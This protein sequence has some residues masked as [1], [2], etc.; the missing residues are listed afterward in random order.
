MNPEMEMWFPRAAEAG[1][2]VLMISQVLVSIGLFS[3]MAACGDDDDFTHNGFS[4]AD[5]TL[6]G[7]AEILPGG[8]LRLTEIAK[9]QKGYAFH[10]TPLRLKKPSGAASF[11]TTFVIAMVGEYPGV[12][13]HGLTFVLS[14]SKGI[15]GAL[16]SQYLGL[17]N[18]TSRGDPSNHLVA[19]EFDTNMSAEF[20][21]I[22]NNHVGIDVNGVR[23]VATRSLSDFNLTISPEN[24]TV[25]TAWVDYSGPLRRIDVYMAFQGKPK[26]LFPVLNASLDLGEHLAQYSYFGFAAS[27][28]TEQYELNCILGW[29]LTV[30]ILPEKEST[31]GLTWFL[32]IGVPALAVLVVSAGVVLFY[33]YRKS[34]KR[35]EELLGT[36]KSLPG[37]PR[38]FSYRDLKRATGNFDEKNKLGHGGFGIVYRG[39]IPGEN[40]QVA[41]KKFSRDQTMQGDFLAE[42]TIIN[43][44]RHRHLVRLLGWC[45]RNG[46]L[47]LVYD[48]MPN[49]SLDDHLFTPDPGRQLPWDLRYQVVT[50]VAA[51][52]HYLHDEYDQRVLHRDV[53][54][55]NVLLDADM[56]AHLGDFGLAKVLPAER[57]HR[58]GDHH[59]FATTDSCSWFAGSFGYIAPECAY[60][61]KATEK[62]DVY[63]MGIV[64]MEL[65]TGRMPTDLQGFGEGVDMVRWVQDGLALP[66][67]E[68]EARL[69][70]HALQPLAPGE[71]SS[72]LEVLDVALQCTTTAPAERPTSREVSDLLRHVSIDAGRMGSGTKTPAA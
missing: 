62:S 45:H 55:S 32:R 31:S 4:G 7:A 61:P 47:L 57:P 2:L 21:D 15:P 39:F 49:G 29:N 66:S 53:K 8:L 38:E 19:V 11:T 58:P 30:E 27:T 5:L 44:L 72:M 40:T 68:R 14:P 10:P 65:V 12:G 28:G 48:Y 17:F 41:V 69:L 46:K 42:L 33:R 20:D 71:Q 37:M 59:D 6:S 36:L 54:A 35:D 70:D 51:A 34:A 18:K 1:V 67:P 26:P 16:P 22:D 3:K 23:S 56:E 50:G 63:S 43:R 9:R 64:L 13:A 24:A 25:Y 52:L 60:S